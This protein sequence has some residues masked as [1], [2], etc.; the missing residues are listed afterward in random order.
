MREKGE[1]NHVTP[2]P[3]TSVCPCCA[4]KPEPNRKKKKQKRNKG[5]KHCDYLRS[6]RLSDLARCVVIRDLLCARFLPHI[7]QC[8]QQA[9]W[10]DLAGCV[11]NMLLPFLLF[12]LF[13]G[14][15]VWRHLSLS[16]RSHCYNL[17]GRPTAIIRNMPLYIS[18]WV[19]IIRF[20]LSCCHRSFRSCNVFRVCCW[21]FVY[22]LQLFLIRIILVV[23]FLVNCVQAFVYALYFRAPCT[24][25]VE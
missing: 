17:L 6:V 10:Y 2:W 4:T 18:Y 23:G 7:C 1:W 5:P 9:G 21:C 19:G 8:F 24:W 14:Y 11:C 20:Y 3:S 25:I 16:I 12:F 15:V 13:V 22:V